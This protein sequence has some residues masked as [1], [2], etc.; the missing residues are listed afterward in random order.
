MK[1]PTKKAAKKRIT[2]HVKKRRPKKKVDPSWNKEVQPRQRVVGEKHRLNFKLDGE[3]ADWARDYAKRH[4]T[5]VTQLIIDH[6]QALQRQEVA[7]RA[8]D[9]EQI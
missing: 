1:K 7:L 6:F 2:Q 3:L 9:A 5:T 4:G 8:Q